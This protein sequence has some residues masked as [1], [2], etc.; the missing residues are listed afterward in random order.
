MSPSAEPEASARPAV[1]AA[2]LAATLVAALAAAAPGLVR[3]VRTWWSLGDWLYP[4]ALIAAVL[5]WAWR[6]TAPRPPRPG[7]A[8]WLGPVWFAIG[9][10]L[11]GLGTLS[12]E[13]RLA[14]YGFVPLGF[15]AAALLR[16]EDLLRRHWPTA[17]LLLLAVPHPNPPT[18]HLIALAKGRVGTVA[19]WT[20]GLCG[21]PASLDGWVIAL[22]HG[23]LRLVDACS[24]ARNQVG[25][26]LVVAAMLALREHS[27]AQRTAL[28]LAT[29][30]AAFLSS[31]LRV[32]C[33]G[34]SQAL[35][36]R[37]L[38]GWAGAVHD[39][40]GLLVIVPAVLL[41]VWVGRTVALLER[42]R[43]RGA[44]WGPESRAAPAGAQGGA[45]WGRPPSRLALG[46][47]ATLVALAGLRTRP[48]P[49]QPPQ[50]PAHLGGLAGRVGSEEGALVRALEADQVQLREYGA[51]ARE[52]SSALLLHF[53]AL[54]A[55][56]NLFVHAPEVCYQVGGW[57]PI[58][59]LDVEVP[60]DRGLGPGPGSGP[61][62][63]RLELARGERRLLV[64]YAYLRGRGEVSPSL[65]GAWLGTIARGLCGQDTA[66][67]L[68]L[69]GT[70]EQEELSDA[71]RA[72][73]LRR[74]GALLQA[75]LSA[76]A[77]PPA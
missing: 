64:H 51:R 46:A 67:Q 18:Y 71:L 27:R 24:G 12:G 36:P 9:L 49:A 21:V 73:E 35:T 10:G 7:G 11:V 16:G 2:L 55:P 74:M 77:R 17:A 5:A 70:A 54:D 72:R 61:L 68:L 50:L 48:A 44:P 63:R 60:W 22:P 52:A 30:P 75:V 58:R 65:L 47:L 69:L 34:M 66:G 23:E 59:A 53:Q 13:W 25:L 42:E 37:W 3:L 1:P 76:D 32:V 39:L 8:R 62:V 38:D 4:A 41:V 57:T 20:L 19:A 40:S 43:S 56:A 26:V 33:V 14:W 15:G 31:V 6:R 29:V 28:L 45:A